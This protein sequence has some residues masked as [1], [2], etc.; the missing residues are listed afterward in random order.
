M[1]KSGRFGR[2]STTPPHT[3]LRFLRY[4]AERPKRLS[5]AQLQ[6]LGWSATEATDFSSTDSSPGTL[7]NARHAG[8]PGSSARRRDQP[9][10]YLAVVGDQRRRPSRRPAPAAYRARAR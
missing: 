7:Q 6:S 1:P 4:P 8:G 5:V 10:E 2:C 3:D 9:I